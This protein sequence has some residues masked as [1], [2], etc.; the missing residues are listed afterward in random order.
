[1]LTGV[2]SAHAAR[3]SF[4]ISCRGFSRLK[5]CIAGHSYR[6]PLDDYTTSSDN[7]GIVCALKTGL[8]LTFAGIL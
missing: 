1:M 6:Y 7:L 8:F 5:T 2:L 4:Q 3:V